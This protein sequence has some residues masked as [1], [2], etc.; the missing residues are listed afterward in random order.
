MTDNK[1]DA[2]PGPLDVP[3]TRPSAL[4]LQNISVGFPDDSSLSSNIRTVDE[5]VGKLELALL[6]AL[7]AAVVIVA[8]YSAIS[9]HFFHSQVG[10]WWNFVVRKGTFAIAMLGAAFATQ[11]QRLL[12]MDLVSRKISPRARLAVS[13]VLKLLTILLAGVLVYIGL[14]L[15]D[16]GEGITHLDLRIFTIT[17]KDAIA[18]IPIGGALIALHSLLHAV[19]DTDY[20]IR[21]KLPPEKAR[22]G[23]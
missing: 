1:D 2:A 3:P 4:S 9:D 6:L 20:L 7:F 12:A 13:L 17:E 19:I 18:V 5:Y 21:N 15:H 14:D 22:T 23:H 10:L 8:S 11:Q 16:K